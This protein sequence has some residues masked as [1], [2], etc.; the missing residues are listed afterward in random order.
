M[1]KCID[2]GFKNS[3]QKSVFLNFF[4]HF[5][6]CKRFFLQLIWEDLFF[7]FCILIYLL[8]WEKKITYSECMIWILLE[9]TFWKD[10]SSISTWC[11]QYIQIYI[12]IKSRLAD[13]E[14]EEYY[15]SDCLNSTIGALSPSVSVCIALQSLKEH[16]FSSLRKQLLSSLLEGEVRQK[17]GYTSGD[18]K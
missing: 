12:Y 16:F 15:S 18:K 10:P 5:V 6:N 1:F 11:R 9:S 2:N 14:E 4:S 3:C 17:E 13:L 8:Q 7:V